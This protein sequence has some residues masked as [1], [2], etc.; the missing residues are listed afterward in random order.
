MIRRAKASDIP[1][2]VEAG[3]RF[4][5]ASLYATYGVSF[6]EE[7]LAS[8]IAEQIN[9]EGACVFIAEIDG[10]FAGGACA[11]KAQPNMSEDF[12][13]VELY[14]WV[15]ESRR[16]GISAARLMRALE[17]WA[18]SSGCKALV[19][20]SMQTIKDSPADSIYERMGYKAIE[21]SWIRGL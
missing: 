21:K 8:T 1:A 4:H 10:E 20:A 12:I 16:G 15:D 14:W 13:A 11:V 6:S 7:K 3:R 5:S 19:M 9:S 2:L 18:K 17:S